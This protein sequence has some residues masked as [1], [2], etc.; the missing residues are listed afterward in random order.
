MSHRGRRNADQILLK[1]LACGATNEA[2]ASQAGVSPATVYRRRQDPQFCK[3]LD[4]LK[5]EMLQRTTAMLTAS[6]MES[7]KTLIELQKPAVPFAVR[8]GAARSALEIG[9]KFRESAELEKRLQAIE[10][11]LQLNAIAG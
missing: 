10:E 5:S 9:A 7:V 1:A 11:Q 3:R 4:E 6:S 8:L 2:A